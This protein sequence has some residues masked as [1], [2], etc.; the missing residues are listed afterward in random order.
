M[1]T[2]RNPREIA[3]TVQMPA[4]LRA[5]GFEPNDRTHRCE[6]VLHGGSNPTAFSWRE[7]GRWRCFSCGRGGD[8]IALAQ[9]ARNFSFRDA[10]QFIAALAGVSYSPKRVS[11]REIE[12]AKKRSEHAEEAAWR[13]R[14]E[15]LRLRSYYRNGLLRAERLWS[16][17]GGELLRADS[18][19]ESEFQ[20]ERMAKLAPV[21]TFFLA[22]YSFLSRADAVTLA[23]FAL[24]ST[25]ERRAQILEEADEHTTEQTARANSLLPSRP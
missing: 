18:E 17:L 4:L 20:W 7:D 6:C 21:I 19:V 11:R 15:V 9:Y 25:L 23:H 14:D 1:N 10:V 5:L 16:R 12:R 22:A 8:R 24:A 2:I 13:I 3:A